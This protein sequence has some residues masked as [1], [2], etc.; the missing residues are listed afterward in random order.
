MSRVRDTHTHTWFAISQRI[1][2]SI[3]LT[4]IWTP[5]ILTIRRTDPSSWRIKTQRCLRIYPSPFLSPS[6]SSTIFRQRS[7][8]FKLTFSSSFEQFFEVNISSSITLRL[9]FRHSC[10]SLK[11][12]EQMTSLELFAFTWLITY[13][14]CK[15]LNRGTVGSNL[16]R[17]R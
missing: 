15:F 7:Y 13:V 12:V 3:K 4:R 5:Q 2:P 10:Q 1:I 11:N 17:S 6:N 9:A 16:G 14:W 8:V